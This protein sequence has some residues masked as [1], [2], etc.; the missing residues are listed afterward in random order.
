MIN[1]RSQKVKGGGGSGRGGVG[2][3]GVGEG[4]GRG[5][6]GVGEGWVTKI[7]NGAVGTTPGQRK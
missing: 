4:W 3:G 2:W 6:G 7:V 5:G 1:G